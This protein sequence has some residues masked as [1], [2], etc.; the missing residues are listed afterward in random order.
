MIPAPWKQVNDRQT[1]GKRTT[2]LPWK[3]S[4][5]KCQQFLHTCKTWT[6][7]NDLP[8]SWFDVSH[9]TIGLFLPLS[10]HRPDD[11]AWP[12]DWKLGN[13]EWE[14][15]PF[16]LSS[17]QKDLLPEDRKAVSSMGRTD[18]PEQSPGRFWK[19]HAKQVS[20][21]LAPGI[22]GQRPPE[23][24]WWQA[25]WEHQ[26]VNEHCLPRAWTWWHECCLSLIPTRRN[27]MKN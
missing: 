5:M 25:P 14:S 8:S 20:P 23:A 18:T 21:P 3:L 2:E 19:R 1:Y 17:T 6:V 7:S 24:Q 27:F 13:A 10:N 9:S 16:T 15:D 4:S 12:S 11:Q 26:W 22:W